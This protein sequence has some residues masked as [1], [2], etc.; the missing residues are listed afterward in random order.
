MQYN[1]QYWSFGKPLV[2][3]FIITK[4]GKL[5]V[6]QLSQYEI[7]HHKTIHVKDDGSITQVL[8]E[9]IL[10]LNLFFDRINEA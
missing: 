5:A 8:E 10:S 6:S 3:N 4:E 2:F 1:Y 7:I 9:K